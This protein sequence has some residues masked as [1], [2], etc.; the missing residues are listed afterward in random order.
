[1]NAKKGSSKSLWLTDDDLTR[2]S[3]ISTATNLGQTE[4]LS[5]IVHAGLAAITANNNRMVLPLQFD[6]GNCTFPNC[7][8]HKKK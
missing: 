7:S 4:L 8:N 1:M 2:L 3:E 5:Q 6:M